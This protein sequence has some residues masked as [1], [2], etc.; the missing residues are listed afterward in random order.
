MLRMQ[1]ARVVEMLR[2]QYAIYIILLSEL[3]VATMAACPSDTC[4]VINC[5]ETSLAMQ[6]IDK[7]NNS[8]NNDSFTFN[9]WP[10][11]YNATD[12][13]QSNFFNFSNITLQ[14]D[15]KF[16][17]DEVI[18]RCPY[19]SDDGDFNSL[20]FDHCTDISIIGLIFTGCGTMSFGSFF[21]NVNNLYVVDS[22][23]R[24]N[25]NNGLGIRSATN[26]SIINC[27]FENS[28]G[29]QNDSTEFL[30]QQRSDTYGGSG[31]GISLQDIAN[32]SITVENCTFKN[33]VALKNS[34]DENDSRPYNYIPFGNGGGIYINLNNVSDVTIRIKNCSFYNNTA[35][36]QG[37]GIVTFLTASSDNVVEIIDS[38]FI[39][40]K[41]I[42]YPLF[43]QTRRSIPDIDNFV[44]EI[45]NKFNVKTFNVSITNALS[46]VPSETIQQRG[47]FGG[48]IIVNFFSKCERNTIL[49]NNS[50]FKENLAIGSA[51]IGIFV[52]EALSFISSGINSNR[53]WISWYGCC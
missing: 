27:T 23:F 38:K 29:F 12:G 40:N 9:I 28:V 10:G 2:I 31:L 18:I 42:G 16:S 32:T 36:H 39:G 37:G 4:A 53:A 20:G 7:L 24:H 35:L 46:D 43:N 44:A 48:A 1:C 49:V 45:N 51:G 50:I 3:L 13:I 47:G 8:Q 52:W 14:K 11:T 26:V 34:S 19:I 25:L 15:P 17:D 41:A 33:N 5:T 21:G 30:I 22:I 6:V